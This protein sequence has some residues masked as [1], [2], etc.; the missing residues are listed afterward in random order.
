M[1]RSSG[2]T[3][4]EILVVLTLTALITGILLQGIQ[5]V[6]FLQRHFDVE[7]FQTQQGFMRI[8]WLRGSINGLVP[9]YDDGPNKFK[10]TD[11]RLHGLT[12]MPMDAP[13]GGL[14]G[15]DLH[16]AFDPGSGESGLYYGDVVKDQR[17]LTWKSAE[18]KFVYLD[19]QGGRHNEWPPFLGIWPQLPAAIII[20][21]G[22]G[23]SRISFVAVP[24]GLAKPSPRQADVYAN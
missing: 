9:D 22:G 4:L 12:T 24:K 15:F 3:L 19:A 10:G 18:G 16:I 8:S 14:Q 7:F 1:R 23:N 20:E 2:F 21:A 11:S 17:I 6:F 5:Q 13:D